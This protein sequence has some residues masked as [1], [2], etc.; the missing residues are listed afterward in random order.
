MLV[1]DF[2]SL[3]LT[4]ALGTKWRGVSDR[5]MGGVSEAVIS[6]ESINDCFYLRLRG[7]VR[8]ERNGGFIEAVLDLTSARDTFDA[9]EYRGLHLL[10]RGNG[11]DY[12]MHIRTPDCVHPWQSYRAHFTAGPSWEK[13]YLPFYNFAS[14]RLEVPLNTGRLKRVGLVAIGRAFSADLMVSHISLYR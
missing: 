5:V 14:H 6:R 10:V 3:D 12:S 13:L 11:E 7:D 2:S 8:L 4:S 9:S 1:D